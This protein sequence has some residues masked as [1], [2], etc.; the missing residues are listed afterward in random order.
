MIDFYQGR[1]S[2]TSLSSSPERGGK[3]K[4]GEGV[5]GRGGLNFYLDVRPKLNSWEG[6]RTR[7]V[8]VWRGLWDGKG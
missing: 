1:S 4:E 3:E 7:G 5:G 2:A 6:W 8:A